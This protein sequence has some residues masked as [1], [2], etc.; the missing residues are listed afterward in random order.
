MQSQ[1]KIN[2]RLRQQEGKVQDV[3]N[4]TMPPLGLPRSHLEYRVQTGL[5]V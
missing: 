5:H 1:K 4:A 3:G 2:A